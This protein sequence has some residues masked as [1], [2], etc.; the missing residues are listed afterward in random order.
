MR[1]F[2]S[3]SLF[4][5]WTI[6]VLFLLPNRHTSK[7][8]GVYVLSCEGLFN[9]L[10]LVSLLGLI[11]VR[12]F[13][14]F[15]L[16]WS[17]LRFF[18]TSMRTIVTEDSNSRLRRANTFCL[19]ASFSSITWLIRA[20]I[21][22]VRSSLLPEESIALQWLFRNLCSTSVIL[23]LFSAFFE[24]WRTVRQSSAGSDFC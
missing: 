11:F 19:I 23:F 12:T 20:L 6:S 10:G 13:A 24:I 5:T 22:G 1:A 16:S 7:F 21:V 2:Q 18:W 4:S 14:N 8:L 9:L 15:N 17:F 3:R